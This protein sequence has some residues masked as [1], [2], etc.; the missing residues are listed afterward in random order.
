MD[1]GDVT[2]DGAT[3]VRRANPKKAAAAAAG[4]AAAAAC[5]LLPFLHPSNEKNYHHH[6]DRS[7]PSPPSLARNSNDH[8]HLECPPLPP[9]MHPRWE[10]ASRGGGGDYPPPAHLGPGTLAVVATP[11]APPDPTPSLSHASSPQQ[12]SYI[13]LSEPRAPKIVSLVR[14]V[15]VDSVQSLQG[16]TC[17]SLLAAAD[18]TL[19]FRCNS[20]PQIFCLSS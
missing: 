17:P 11:P 5:S 4:S 1:D 8:L 19:A 14:Q 9:S 13:D 16:T 20:D 10:G 18:E 7:S 6:R 12:N 15:L 3:G 2:E